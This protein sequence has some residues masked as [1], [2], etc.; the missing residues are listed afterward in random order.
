MFFTVENIEISKI[1]N[2]KE[3][4]EY[5]NV[6]ELNPATVNVFKFLFNIIN[7]LKNIISSINIINKKELISISF[8]EESPIPKN[9]RVESAIAINKDILRIIFLFFFNLN[10]SYNFFPHSGQNFEFLSISH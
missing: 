9:K 5:K 2:I 10:T 1:L 3:H 7:V 4:I 8:F 6:E